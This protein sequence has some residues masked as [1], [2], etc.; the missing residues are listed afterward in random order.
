MIIAITITMDTLQIDINIKFI[1]ILSRLVLEQNKQLLQIIADEEGISYNK[2]NNFLPSH[3]ELKK[4]L[5]ALHN[6]EDH[7]TLREKSNST[8]ESS[9]SYSEP[10]ES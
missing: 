1:E 8:S 3:Y 7:H 10:E 6:N 4:Q 2:I 5:L 9:V